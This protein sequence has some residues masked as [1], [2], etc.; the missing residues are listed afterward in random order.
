MSHIDYKLTK[1]YVF[2]NALKKGFLFR[3]FAQIKFQVV[4]S[5]TCHWDDWTRLFLL[6][7]FFPVP[8]RSFLSRM[9]E[10]GEWI[11]KRDD[12]ELQLLRSVDPYVCLCTWK[13][14][15]DVDEPVE[16]GE[17]RRH[18][19]ERERLTHVAQD[20]EPRG[21][22]R[23]PKGGGVKRVETSRDISVILKKSGTCCV[24]HKSIDT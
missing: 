20:L 11:E 14:G 6:V 13:S 4:F 18:V 23:Y 17:H 1:M 24:C 19:G 3:G 21:G 7:P 2:L 16:G 12:L 10:H 8:H 22:G 9:T 5:G 15:D